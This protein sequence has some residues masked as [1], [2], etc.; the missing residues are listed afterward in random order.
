MPHFGLLG[1]HL[2]H[3]LSPRLHEEI[4]KQRG[5]S[6]SYTL[7]ELPRD[8]FCAEFRSLQATGRYRG[9]N[10]TI[11]YK[12]TV[13][14]LLSHISPQA[15]AIGA[16]NTILFADDGQA[17]GYNTDYYGVL[18]LLSENRIDIAG[19]KALLFGA[20]GVARAVV[21][22]LKDSGAT[23]IRIASRS[24]LPTVE[25]SADRSFGRSANAST[26][27]PLGKLADFM[28]CP[29]ISYESLTDG[30]SVDLIVNCTPVGMWPHE[31]A[32]PISLEV[33]KALRPSA[34]LDMIYNPKET[35]LL[36]FARELS[37]T[38]ACGMTMLWEQARKAQDIWAGAKL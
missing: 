17:V 36:R 30:L 1:E 16:V 32:S 19:K 38:A 11:P 37:I 28:N 6:G 13:M 22:A 7:I 2:G 27:A 9:L 33:M 24:V 4:M 3:S 35:L 5:I 8:T 20:G 14:P 21:A 26:E 34:A 18:A 29:L 10:V 12:Q 25:P 31:D 15:Q 23:D